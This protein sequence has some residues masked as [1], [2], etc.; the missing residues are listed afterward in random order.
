MSQITE[1]FI[2]DPKEVLEVGQTVKVKLIKI[3]EKTG[4][5]QL[6]MRDL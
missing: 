1:R 6:T 3:D 2:K 4:K 5:I